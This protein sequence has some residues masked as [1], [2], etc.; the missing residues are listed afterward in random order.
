MDET[1]MQFSVIRVTSI[2]YE[3]CLSQSDLSTN[4]IHML[5]VSSRPKIIQFLCPVFYS[6]G[7]KLAYR[8]RQHTTCSFD[9][10]SVSCYITLS[11]HYQQAQQD[12]DS[13]ITQ[14]L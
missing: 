9:V 8:H 7:L 3:Q 14:Q 10:S 13:K 1:V 4:V 5:T 6:I 12:T 2:A 11:A